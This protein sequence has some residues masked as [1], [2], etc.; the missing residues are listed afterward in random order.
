[1]PYRVSAPPNLLGEK[2]ARTTSLVKRKFWNW[3]KREPSFFLFLYWLLIFFLFIALLI[4]IK[5]NEIQENVPMIRVT[6]ATA[7]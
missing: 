2:P 4:N 6:L 1:M 3:I 5:Y 7:R